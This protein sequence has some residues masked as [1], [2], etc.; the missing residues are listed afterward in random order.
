MIIVRK[1]VFLLAF[2]S[3]SPQAQTGSS[4]QTGNVNESDL[5]HYG[6]LIDV[7]VVGSFE[8]DWRGTLNPEG[9]LDGLDRASEPVYALCRSADEVAADITRQY[10]K[11]LREPKIVVSVLDRSNRALMM[12][13]GAV[14]NPQRFRIQRQVRLNEILALSGGIIDTARGEI[15]IFRPRDLN[16][17]TSAKTSTP[18]SFTM[19]RISIGDLLNGSPEANPSVLSG[20]VVTVTEAPPVYIIGGVATPRGISNKT[21]LTLS[22][23]IA[24][25]GGLTRD[26]VESDITIY[27]RD[28]KETRIITADL[29]KIRAGKQ[30]DLLLKPYDVVDVGQKGR[31]RSKL[32]P[33][34]V[35][36]PM[37]RDPYKYPIR[38][39]E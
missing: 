6:D 1:I 35:A 4:I 23:A 10:S 33:A 39:I 12:L 17:D 37:N 24:S 2:F 28:A 19:L 32:P 9:F 25:V 29:K 16:C 26:G 14:K 30:D 22:R 36:D 34:V 21:D 11:T 18:A 15:T 38:I 31:T 8:F 27:R 13:L 20:D 3:I 5:I 7:D